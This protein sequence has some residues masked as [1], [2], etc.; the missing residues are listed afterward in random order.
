MVSQR[1]ELVEA[2]KKHISNVEQ[3]LRKDIASMQDTTRTILRN[4]EDKFKL[5]MVYT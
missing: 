5:T 2:M 3:A 4:W 1:K